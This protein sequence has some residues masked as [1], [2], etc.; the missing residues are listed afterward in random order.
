MMKKIFIIFMTITISLSIISCETE[1]PKPENPVFSDVQ[2]IDIYYN[3]SSFV[4]SEINDYVEYIQV[5]VFTSSPEIDESNKKINTAPI[6]GSRSGLA[7]LSRS[8]VSLL[9]DYESGTQDFTGA[10][11]TVDINHYIVVLGFDSNL[12]L[13]HA[14]PLSPINL[15]D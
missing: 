3:G 5:L 6:S 10:P 1:P 15:I 13:T 9:F 4:F 8:S 2:K 11:Y 7:D 12:N 14:S